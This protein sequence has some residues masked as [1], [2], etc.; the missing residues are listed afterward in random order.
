[1]LITEVMIDQNALKSYAQSVI[2]GGGVTAVYLIGSAVSSA[3]P[4]D[5][6]ILYVLNLALPPDADHDDE[7]L[8][9]FLE[10][11]H[12][13]DEYDTFFLAGQTWWHLT[14]GAGHSLMRNDEY[15]AEQNTRPKVL[16]AS[17]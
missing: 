11:C 5:I 6:D 9:E 7:R 3:A 15:A 10:H 16:L 13:S 17:A 1:M 2:Q 4:N 12:I 14:R 8:W